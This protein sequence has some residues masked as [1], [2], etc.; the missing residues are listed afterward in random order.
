MKE[1]DKLSLNEIKVKSFT[2]TPG[3]HVGGATVDCA[4]TEINCKPTERITCVICPYTLGD[5]QTQVCCTET[6][7]NPTDQMT[8]ACC[9]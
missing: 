2:T 8:Q 7:C 5:G 9:I 3:I 1:K 6:A 4:F